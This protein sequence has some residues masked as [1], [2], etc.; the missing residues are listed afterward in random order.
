MAVTEDRELLEDIPLQTLMDKNIKWF[1][2]DFDCPTDTE[3]QLLDSYFH[4]HPLAIEDCM[5]LLQRPKVDHYEDTHFFVVHSLH[6]E[7]LIAEEINFF[8]GPRGIVTFHLA[9]SEEI[10]EVWRRILDPSIRDGKDHN[11]VSYLIMDQLVD[12]YFPTL[13]R[14]EDQLNDLEVEGE[15]KVNIQVMTEQ[16]YDIRADLLR[17]RR[18]VIPMRDLLYRIISSD[19]VPMVKEHH[20]YFTDIH[21]HL[22][23]LTEMIESNREMT[24]DLRDSYN[25]LRSNRMNA[26]MKTLTVITTIFM[27]LTFIAG[28]Y[29]MNFVNM[30][31]LNWSWGYFI[32]IGVMVLLGFGMYL[33]FKR[34]GWFD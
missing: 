22:L 15:M 29:G 16:I 18:S 20:A 8:L 30:P 19:K 24:T 10:D 13:Y 9:S 28:V 5:H 11:Y 21:D 25:S 12:N 2:V 4:F 14:I 17:L 26:I 23:K 6:P 34:K 32:V 33:W 27:P 7:T 3:V 31:E 1:W